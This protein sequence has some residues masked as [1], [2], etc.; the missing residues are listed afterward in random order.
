MSRVGNRGEGLRLRLLL[1]SLAVTGGVG[2]RDVA[3]EGFRLL[4]AEGRP[5]SGAVSRPRRLSLESA[6]DSSDQDAFSSENDSRFAHACMLSW[7]HLAVAQDVCIKRR[8]TNGFE[9]VKQ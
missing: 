9:E 2:F 1:W 5:F 7:V 8:T 4:G 3:G 6:S